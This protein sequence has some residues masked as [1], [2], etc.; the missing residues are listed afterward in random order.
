[1]DI[2]CLKNWLKRYLGREQSPRSLF[3]LMLTPTEERVI[4][5]SNN[6]HDAKFYHQLLVNIYKAADYLG[7][8]SRK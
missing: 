2:L 7:E 1:M 8:K 3:F 5:D 4:L 6:M